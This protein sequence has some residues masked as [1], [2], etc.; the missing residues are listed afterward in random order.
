MILAIRVQKSSTRSC[1]AWRSWCATDSR[2]SRWPSCAALGR[3][4][5][6]MGGALM[7]LTRC[8]YSSLGVGPP[9]KDSLRSWILG[10]MEVRP[11]RPLVWVT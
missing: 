7:P 3:V 10:N 11:R 4:P 6:C 5:N 8:W 1:T 9:T 2:G